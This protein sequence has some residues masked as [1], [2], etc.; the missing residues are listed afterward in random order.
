MMKRIFYLILVLLI[1]FAG[2]SQPDDQI[3]KEYFN[4]G[5]DKVSRKNFKGAIA[6]FSEAIMRTPGFK[7]AYE[8]RGVAKYYLLDLMGAI[9][10]YTKALEIDPNDYNTSGRRG[11]AK[12]YLQ[13]YRGAITDFSKAIKGSRDNALY[14]NIRGQ[15]KYQ[16]QDY[17]GAIADFNKVIKSWSGGKN[18]K[19][20]AFYFRGLSEIHLGQKDSGCLDLSKAWKLGYTKAYESIREYCN[21]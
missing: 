9:D 18:Q 21:K 15:A 10:D 12:F 19:S 2:Y 1:S 8:N 20:K 14:Y 13:D 4:N 17:E 11:W 3:A 5:C 16:I 6:D 7:Q